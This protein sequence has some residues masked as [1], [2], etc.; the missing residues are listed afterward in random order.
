[1]IKMGLLPVSSTLKEKTHADILG[2]NIKH[3]FEDLDIPIYFLVG[4][5]D[6]VTPVEIVKSLHDEYK[7]REKYL[8]LIEGEHHSMRTSKIV[9]EIKE[10]IDLVFSTRK[11][12]KI[13]KKEKIENPKSTGKKL[14]RS[15]E[16]EKTPI[17]IKRSQ[18]YIKD[19][20]KLK[21]GERNKKEME[22]EIIETRLEKDKVEDIWVFK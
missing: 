8:N 22:E 13:E 20:P 6:E 3:V 12:K 1:M 16:E 2:I 18:V 17:K 9:G 7:Y 4:K 11:E 5:E 21:K 19:K 14:Q 15:M 10:F